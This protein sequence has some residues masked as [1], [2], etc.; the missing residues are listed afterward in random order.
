MLVS[1]NQMAIV[2]P[3]EKNKSYLAAASIKNSCSLE[4]AGRGV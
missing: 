2:R 4:L 1:L 3:H